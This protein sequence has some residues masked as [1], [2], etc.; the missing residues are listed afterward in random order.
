MNFDNAKNVDSDTLV[1]ELK[2]V[3][4][5]HLNNVIE[6][7]ENDHEKIYSI[8]AISQCLTDVNEALLG[9]TLINFEEGKQKEAVRKTLV[10]LVEMSA[11]QVRS[12]LLDN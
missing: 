6:K 7:S 3:I 5:D 4:W 2:D 8:S 12:A 9:S 1:K 10:Q 11:F